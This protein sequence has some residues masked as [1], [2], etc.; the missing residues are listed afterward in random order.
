MIETARTSA[1]GT[2][3]G[4]RSVR[5]Q[6]TSAEKK[7]WRD[8]PP[9]D[10]IVESQFVRPLYIGET[11]LPFRLQE[12]KLA[13]IP[14]NGSTLMSG[15]HDQIDYYPGLAA[16][17]RQA[18]NLWETHRSSDRLS[19][20]E[21]L[22]FMRGLS[23]QFPAPQHR[24]A[25]TASGTY[26]AAAL[27]TDP[28][29]VIEHKLYWATATDID[30]GRYLTAILNS[31]VLT[32]LVRPLQS[33]GAF[34]PRDFDKY[35]FNL[36]IPLFSQ[37]IRVHRQ[38]VDL[39]ISAEGIASAIEIKEGTSFQATRRRIRATLADKG[40]GAAINEIVR[41]ILT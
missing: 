7:P 16:W 18:E 8:L 27:V 5:S 32:E 21:R 34:G 35:I 25:Y 23:G 10:G 26:L 20:I 9:L 38:L 30:E 2:G 31:D 4:R 6:R 3:A 24:V 29:A 28:L 1:L 40:I 33:V 36:P 39:A 13:V 19:L 12:P 17:W 14:W 22:D 11:V 15:D 37:N 41:A